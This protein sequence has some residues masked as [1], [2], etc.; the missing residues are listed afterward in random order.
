MQVD[1][2]VLNSLAENGGLIRADGGMLVMT[3]GAKEAASL[4]V[5]STNDFR[6]SGGTFLRAL[7][8]DGSSAAPLPTSWP[9]F[10][11]CKAW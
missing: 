7:G 10:M 1:Q 9:T 2:S 4:P 8:G 6:F 5:F 3:A 11:A